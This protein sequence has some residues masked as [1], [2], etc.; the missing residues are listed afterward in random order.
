MIKVANNGI[1]YQGIVVSVNQI[2]REKTELQ[3]LLR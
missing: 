3:S 1:A 2:I